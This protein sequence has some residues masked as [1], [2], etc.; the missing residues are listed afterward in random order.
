MTLIEHTITVTE[1][2]SGQRLDAVA[3]ACLTDYSRS[4]LQEWIKSGG[5]TVDGRQY[6]PKQKVFKGDKLILSVKL[7]EDDRWLPEPIDFNV[8]FEDSEIIVIDKPQGLVVHPGAGVANAT[9][10]NGLLHRFPELSELPR[11]GIV[12]R[13]DKDTTGIMVIARSLAAHTSLVGQL[14]DRSMG[15]QYQALVLGRVGATGT[16]DEPIDRHPTAR[17]KMAVVVGGKA[18][19]TSYQ[20]LRHYDLDTGVEKSNRPMQTRGYSHI[21]CQLATGRT[22]QIRVH[23]SHIGHPLVGDPVYH[24]RRQM[25]ANTPKELAEPLQQFNRQALHAET[26]KLVHPAT[27]ELMAFTA[28]LAD[29]FKQL[30]DTLNQA[31]DS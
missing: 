5:L 4:R 18:A 28:P 10:L 1:P 8:I 20:C 25:S 22:H 26:L 27:G 13:L 19:Q 14:Q 12:H 30:L 24:S 15:R 29:D 23:L 9:L 11:A 3:A 6:K 17:I 7:V 16:I 21:M 2:F 31:Y